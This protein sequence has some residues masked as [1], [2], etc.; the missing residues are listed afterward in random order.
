MRQILNWHPKFNVFFLDGGDILLLSELDSFSLPKAHFSLFNQFDGKRTTEQIL[1]K[2][3]AEK[4]DDAHFFYQLEKFKKQQLLL[5]Q[6]IEPA[7]FIKKH[8]TA[9]ELLFSDNNYSVINLSAANETVLKPWLVLLANIDLSG[10][11][12]L[13]LTFI[14]LDDF[15][16]P[17]LK[18]EAPKHKRICLIKICGERIWLG[19]LLPENNRADYLQKLQ[20]RLKHNNPTLAL[21][22]SLYPERLISTPYR[23]GELLSDALAVKVSVE[24]NQQLTDNKSEITLINR[25]NLQVK[26]HPLCLFNGVEPDFKK[27]I[28]SELILTSC[29][30]NFN[31]D[32]G[33][34]TISAQQTV[35]AIKPFISPIT[36]LITHLALLPASE[37]NPVKIYSSAFFKKPASETAFKLKNDSFVHSCMGKGVS[38]IQSQ[39]S[40][41]CE[42]IERYSAHYQG[43]EPL[44]LSEKTLLDKRCYDFQQLVPYSAEQYRKFNDQTHA[45]ALLK[46]AAATYQDEAVHWL[47]AWSLTLSEHVYLPL[48]HCFANIPF[49]DDKYARWHSNGCAAGNTL[50]EAILQALFELIERD[51]SAVWW[52]NKI[53]RPEFDMSRIDKQQFTLLEETL[54]PGFDFWVL[55]LTHDIG[56]PVMVAVGQDKKTQGLSFGFGCHLQSELAALRALTELCQ[57]IPIRDQ[58][59]APFDFNAVVQESY[60]FP[61]DKILLK[62]SDFIS[63]GDIKI[64][65]ENIVNR[66]KALNFETLVVN[67]SRDPLPVKAAKVFVPGLCHIWPQLANS[68]LYQLPLDLGWLDRANTEQTINPQALYI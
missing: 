16:N 55:T 10:F 13:P 52:Y 56:V 42:A 32:G 40:A 21:L 7:V 39:A 37:N 9:S 57:L 23:A 5:E 15:L 35:D 51:A 19:P 41:L 43:D 27:Q 12:D 60:L 31:K 24:L 38:H 8:A 26:R 54:K 6:S 11:S 61:A 59:D 4:Q 3:L 65:I 49:A 62:D 34:R 48:T 66:L 22:E 33:S 28:L 25:Y 2:S 44:Y 68:R 20:L 17:L 47:P 30:A 1:E 58:N 63:N 36:G 53:E 50:E 29:P 45:D 18:T 46:Q 14:L 67:Y 64:D